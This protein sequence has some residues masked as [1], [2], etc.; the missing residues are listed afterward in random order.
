VTGTGRQGAWLFCLSIDCSS[1][2][3][4]DAKGTASGIAAEVDTGS[5]AD[6]PEGDSAWTAGWIAWEMGAIV[7]LELRSTNLALSIFHLFTLFLSHDC[8]IDQVLK[9]EEGMIHQLVV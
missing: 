1:D 6:I 9:G 3:A 4:A 2:T 7:A 8:S 5:A